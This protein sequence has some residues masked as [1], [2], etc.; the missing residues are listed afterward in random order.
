[1]ASFLS[2]GNIQREIVRVNRRMGTPARLYF[3]RFSLVDFHVSGRSAQVTLTSTSRAG[4]P[5]LH[6]SAEVAG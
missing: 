6:R 2:E 3:V 4:V 1:M 5:K